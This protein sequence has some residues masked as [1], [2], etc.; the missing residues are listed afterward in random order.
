MKREPLEVIRGSGNLYRDLGS[1]NPEIRQFKAILAAEIIK[2]MD[3]RKLT[4]RQAHALTGIDSG[5]FSRVRNADFRRISI[6]R[7]VTMAH[8]L[9]ARIEIKI[10][11]GQAIAVATNPLYRA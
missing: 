7:L 4:V 2:R 10:R 9:G 3:R 8:R 11:P 1:A 6:E 5:D